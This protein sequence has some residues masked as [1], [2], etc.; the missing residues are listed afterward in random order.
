MKPLVKTKLIKILQ[1]LAVFAIVII[2]L[3]FAALKEYRSI[4]IRYVNLWERERDAILPG[5]VCVGDSLT[6]GADSDFEPYPS[7]LAEMVKEEICLLP[8]VNLGHGGEE[9]ATILAQAGG[10]PLQ[11]HAFDIP[12]E[13]VETPVSL[14]PVDNQ[15]FKLTET[16]TD[17]LLNPCFV[18]GVEGYLTRTLDNQFY[19]ERKSAGE[20]VSV[21]EGERVIPAAK[22]KYPSYLWIIFVGANGGYSSPQNLI[23]QQRKM[24]ETL[25]EGNDRYL[26]ITTT[27]E[28]A[29]SN[30]DVEEACEKEY[31]EKYLNLREYLSTEAMT[32]Y[33][34]LPT[35]QD[36]ADME[37]GRNPK[38]FRQDGI[39]YNELG[40]RIVA[41]RI[42]EQ[43]IKLGYFDSLKEFAE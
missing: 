28:D 39:H 29:A 40:T 6:A 37:A 13:T 14:Y 25:A 34:I 20:P 31:G 26:I 19:F 36:L 2:P 42:Y 16:E 5:I 8:V 3:L 7:L 23:D 32:D 11:I 22:G 12:A 4:H 15:P 10:L 43:L 17:A 30:R 35:A 24:L 27:G 1:C 41:E 9:S 33:G 38:S 21:A 18:A